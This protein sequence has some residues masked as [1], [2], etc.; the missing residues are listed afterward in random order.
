MSRVHDMG[1]RYGDGAIDPNESDEVFPYVWHGR[2]LALTLA[3]GGLGQ[4]NLDISRHA[5]EC[6]SPKDYTRFGYYEK[7]IAGLTDLLVNTGVI[8]QEELRT[9]TPT[10]NSPLQKR[11]MQAEYVAKILA[12]GGPSDRVSDTA[13]LFHVGD[14]VT[15]R[16]AGNTLVDGGHTRLPSYARGKTGWI[17]ACHGS[18]VFPDSNAHRLGEAPEPLYSV[19]FHAREMW[20]NPEHPEDEIVLDLWQSY[21]DPA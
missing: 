11:K 4:W 20:D 1:G 17:I 2:A 19:G 6:L 21:L 5:R 7:W 3:A 12:S 18:H 14:S 13:A 15:T 16:A 8:T 9:Q 10:P